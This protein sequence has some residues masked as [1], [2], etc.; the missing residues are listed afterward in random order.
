LK[1]SIL[2]VAALA[3]ISASSFAS[4][5]I[6]PKWDELSVGYTQLDFDDAFELSGVTFSGTTLVAESFFVG[7][8]YGALKETV[9]GSKVDLTE[10]RLGG[11]VIM[12]VG[13]Q[14]HVYFRANYINLEAGIDSVSADSDGFGAAV[15]VRY[16]IT[17]DYEL[18]FSAEHIDIDSETDLKVEGELR[19]NAA[20]KVAVVLKY[21]RYED[22]NSTYLGAS[23]YF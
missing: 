10:V 1:K 15:G 21:A 13:R 7:G 20:K 12:P 23:Y 2:A 18:G 8:S 16:A 4:A 14:T 19:I 17:P 6:S 5:A 3:A 11:G 22:A 9:D